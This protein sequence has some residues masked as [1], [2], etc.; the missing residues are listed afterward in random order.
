AVRP[1]R[2]MTVPAEV[3]RGRAPVSATTLSF[4]VAGAGPWMGFVHGGAG[5]KVHWW[6]QVPFFSRSFTCLTYDCRGFGSS[7]LGEVP[8]G[9]AVLGDDLVGLL[10]HLEV[11]SAVLIG[12]SMG[13]GAV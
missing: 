8:A 10:D 13:G 7:P 5:T 12:H 4:E 1:R 11:P 9:D 3:R 2:P 6:Q